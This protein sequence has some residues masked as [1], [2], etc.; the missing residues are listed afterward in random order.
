MRETIASIIAIL[1]IAILFS[2]I[3]ACVLTWAVCFICSLFGIT[4]AFSWKLVIA[5]WI[6][7]SVLTTRVKTSK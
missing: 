5:I 2:F 3:G 6:I 7:A 1:L 4:L